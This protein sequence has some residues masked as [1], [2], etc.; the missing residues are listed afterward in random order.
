MLPCADVH[1]K[2]L[3]AISRELAVSMEKENLPRSRIAAT[4]G[5]STAAISQYVS[6]KRG[7]KKLEAKAVEACR[8][9]AKRIAG[10]K[11]K[12]GRIDIEISRI[13][14]LAK[15][16]GLGRNDPCAICMSASPRPHS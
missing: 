16:S 10:G 9:L 1:W 14:V 8:K 5:T 12:G 6:G 15:K 3:P 4:L 13:L 11:V 7:G 2:L